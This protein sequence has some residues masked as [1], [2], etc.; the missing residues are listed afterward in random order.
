MNTINL[1]ISLFFL[2]LT[3]LTIQE[4]INRDEIKRNEHNNRDNN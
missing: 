2:I 3:I 1:L 4:Q